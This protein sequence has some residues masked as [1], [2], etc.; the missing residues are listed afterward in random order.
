MCVASGIPMSSALRL[1][2]KLCEAGILRRQ[3]D[4]F[5]GRRS[6]MTIEPEIVHRLGAYFAEGAE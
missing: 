5:D 4:T 3:P 1:A 6:I 2:Q